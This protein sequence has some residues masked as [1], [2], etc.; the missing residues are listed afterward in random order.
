MRFSS[1][2]IFCFENDVF[3]TVG[4]GM[5]ERVSEDSRSGKGESHSHPFYVNIQ[6]GSCICLNA[7]MMNHCMCT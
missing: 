5:S 2:K 3:L 4:L 6:V 7:F 1:T